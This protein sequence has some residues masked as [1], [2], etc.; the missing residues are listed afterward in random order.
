MKY[1]LDLLL[2]SISFSLFL[3]EHKWSDKRTKKY[4]RLRHILIGLF[5]LTAISTFYVTYLDSQ[6]LSRL[7]NKLS[8]IQKQSSK[9]TDDFRPFI[10]KWADL[11]I[12][13]PRITD[14]AIILIR[15]KMMEHVKYEG[16][17]FDMRYEN[18][19]ANR[20]RIDIANGNLL[21]LTLSDFEGKEYST[22]GY[23][24]IDASEPIKLEAMW[25]FKW[26]FIAIRFNGKIIASS[27]IPHT[28]L[29]LSSKDK[30]S[31][32]ITSLNAPIHIQE[33][34]VYTEKSTKFKLFDME[35]FKK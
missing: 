22:E 34:N 5:I 24:E 33:L 15:L 7:E 32:N 26:N 23:I 18:S 19:S 4:K 20:V 13:D 29:D 12:N 28:I 35:D 31:I 16:A 27:H 1:I 21:K 17:I 25:S 6:K 9:L 8:E 3:L 14:G 30:Y 2:I 10:A 11:D